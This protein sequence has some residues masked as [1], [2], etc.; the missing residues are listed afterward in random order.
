MNCF[1]LLRLRLT[2]V[3]YNVSLVALS[4]LV[5]GT[6]RFFIVFDRSIQ[7]RIGWQA[8]FSR[9]ILL[10]QFPDIMNKILFIHPNIPAQFR[11]IAALY[12]NSSGQAW[13][14]LCIS[15]HQCPQGL[16]DPRRAT[17]ALQAG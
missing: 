1:W 2:P 4:R 12:C 5:K 11:H 6:E 7:K 9:S 15:H 8:L 3:D 10:K 14:P 13:L 16:D 17:P